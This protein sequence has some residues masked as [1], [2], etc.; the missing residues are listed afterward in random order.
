M[1]VIGAL[2]FILNRGWNGAI[3]VGRIERHLDGHRSG[4]I[5]EDRAERLVDLSHVIEAA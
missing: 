1:N 5:M 2:G 3:A 4:G